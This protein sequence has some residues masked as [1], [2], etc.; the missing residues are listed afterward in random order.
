MTWSENIEPELA[1]DL[2]RLLDLANRKITSEQLVQLAEQVSEG[3]RY[4]DSQIS[5]RD[6]LPAL[7][8]KVDVELNH[9]ELGFLSG[10]LWHR[11]PALIGLQDIQY[12]YLI[13]DTAIIR[14]TGLLQKAN[15]NS[16]SPIDDFSLQ[17]ML[18]E[19]ADLQI[20][21]TWF[22]GQSSVTSG[23]IRNIN[24]DS[25]DISGGKSICTIVFAQ[26]VALRF[27]D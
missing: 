8:S 4:E 1:S 13:F 3:I 16:G 15:E 19:F 9:Q 14:I 7:G 18:R 27:A 10:K 24:L 12:S 17:L 23:K 22:I 26:L 20:T 5:W 25:V 6:R 2:S 21:L 11:S